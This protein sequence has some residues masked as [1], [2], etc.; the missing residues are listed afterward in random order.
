ML[1]LFPH[2]KRENRNEDEMEEMTVNILNRSI[3]TDQFS[4]YRFRGET[5]ASLCLYDYKSIVYTTEASGVEKK[6]SEDINRYA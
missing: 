6:Q 5:L 1:A 2:L 3:A 4:D